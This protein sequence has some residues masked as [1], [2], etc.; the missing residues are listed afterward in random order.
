MKYLKQIPTWLLGLIF[1]V[2]GAIYFLHLPMPAMTGIAGA[3]AGIL[4]S[5]GYMTVVKVL[6]VTI[7]ILL[8]IPR[9]S[10]LALILI[11]PIAVNIFLFDTLISQGLGFGIVLV[12]LVAIALYINRESYMP[13]IRK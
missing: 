7:G 13:I 2:F 12:V 6:E 9:T 11:A 4:Y 8:F 1:V 10:K 5:T 3:F